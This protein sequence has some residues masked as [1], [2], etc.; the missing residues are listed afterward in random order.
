MG[1]C[2]AQAGRAAAAVAA[3]AAAVPLRLQV[4]A[5][6]AAGRPA[7][8]ASPAG[9]LTC[10]RLYISSSRRRSLASWPRPL[11]CRRAGGGGAARDHRPS[12]QAGPRLASS[13]KRQPPPSYSATRVPTDPAVP[14]RPS[15]PL[16]C[17]RPN[18]LPTPSPPPATRPH[19]PAPAR[20][21]PPHL[22]AEGA[23][24]VVVHVGQPA[25]LLQQL[26]RD[27]GPRLA[28]AALGGGGQRVQR[29]ALAALGAAGRRGRGG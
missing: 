8:P 7:R 22:F 2:V 23:R 17:L 15:P 4:W 13:P 10:Q 27:L 9:R 19:P 24:E 14:P 28:L 29:P 12:S 6:P 3:A 16:P 5:W 1:S 21:P 26:Q 20:P 25:R 18:P 11:N